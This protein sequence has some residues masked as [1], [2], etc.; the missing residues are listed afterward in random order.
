MGCSCRDPAEQLVRPAARGIFDI[1]PAPST[2]RLP[3]GSR[4]SFSVMI[5]LFF[6]TQG[7]PEPPARRVAQA[8]E[9]A[10]PTA[11]NANAAPALAGDP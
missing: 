4:M 8:P 7:R 6:Q 3:S 1:S 10:A 5:N 9:A 2:L 11:V